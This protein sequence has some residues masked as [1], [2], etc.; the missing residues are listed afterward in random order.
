V[1]AMFAKNGPQAI[2]VSDWLIFIKIFSKTAELDESKLGRKH[3]LEVLYKDCSFRPNAFT[4]M[5]ATG[6]SCFL[7][8]DI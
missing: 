8:V 4:N 2:L 1:A 3:L 6:N 7:L 5:S